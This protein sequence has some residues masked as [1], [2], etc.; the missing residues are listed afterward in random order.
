MGKL[1]CFLIDGIYCWFWPNDHRPPHFNAKRRGKWGVKVFFMKR[2]A[3]MIEKAK[4]S[5]RI[6][7]ADRKALSDM[8]EQ[9]REDLL[10]EWEKKVNYD[11]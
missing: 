1:D 7:Q 4:W 2:K 5:G 3:E 10:K 9:H 8:T 6:S 11:D